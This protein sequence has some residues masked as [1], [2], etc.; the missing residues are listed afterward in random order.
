MKAAV[1]IP[2]AD[3]SVITSN[4]LK[5]ADEAVMMDILN[6]MGGLPAPTGVSMN[7][8]TGESAVISWNPMMKYHVELCSTG[9]VIKNNCSEKCIMVMIRRSQ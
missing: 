2:S 9:E 8:I 4:Q 1:C 7:E 6:V 5:L 3:L